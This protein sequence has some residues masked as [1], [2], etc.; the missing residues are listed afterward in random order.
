MSIV[1]SYTY[2]STKVTTYFNFVNL[3]YSYLY[4]KKKLSQNCH[5]FYL[6]DVQ[7]LDRYYYLA[8]TQKIKC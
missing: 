4:K 6:L 1:N 3:L 5:K 2:L 8:L 7:Y